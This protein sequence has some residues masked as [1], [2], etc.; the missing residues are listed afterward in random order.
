MANISGSRKFT[1]PLK[2]ES[3][4]LEIII[5][6]C[7]SNESL[8]NSNIALYQNFKDNNVYLNI[9]KETIKLGA[10]ILNIKKT[11]W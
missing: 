6:I 11:A 5:Q 2:K 9:R 7:Y 8:K 10:E 1:F 4:Y 3:I